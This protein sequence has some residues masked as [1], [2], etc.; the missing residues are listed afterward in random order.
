MT[1]RQQQLAKLTPSKLIELA[2]LSA[3]LEQHQQPGKKSL[4]SHK[5]D[6]VRRFLENVVRVVPLESIAYAIAYGKDEV[7]LQCTKAL[8]SYCSRQKL[9]LS[10]LM[11][12]GLM[13]ACARMSSGISEDIYI[14]A[15]EKVELTEIMRTLLSGLLDEAQLSAANLALESSKLVLEKAKLGEEH[16]INPDRMPRKEVLGLAKLYNE[17]MD[18]HDKQGNVINAVSGLNIEEVYPITH[19]NSHAQMHMNKS[20]QLQCPLD[21][22][23]SGKMKL[24]SLAKKAQAG[25]QSVPPATLSSQKSMSSLDNSAMLKTVNDIRQQDLAICTALLGGFMEQQVIDIPLVRSRRDRSEAFSLHGA[26]SVGVWALSSLNYDDIQPIFARCQGNQLLVKIEEYVKAI[27]SAKSMEADDDRYA[28]KLQF[29]VQGMKKTVSC[30]SQYISYSLERQLF[31]LCDDKIDLSMPLDKLVAQWGGLFKNNILSLVA[32]SH[33]PLIARWLKWALMVHN[34]R[35]EL[36]KYTAVGVAGLVN[37]GK[38]KLVNSLFG[39]NVSAHYQ[40]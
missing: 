24:S 16:K 31:E 20:D 37:S 2:Y 23:R 26:A 8:L 28:A 10:D 15:R 4:V 39:I 34:L 17:V 22:L 6:V 32:L 1:S 33:R 14:Q 19:K 21:I 18:E 11:T 30:N 36:A 9:P 3:L 38:S 35:E 27:F 5:V 12:Y 13:G 7:A 29:I 40:Q 25:A